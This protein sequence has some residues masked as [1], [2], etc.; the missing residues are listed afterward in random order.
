MATHSSILS[1]RIPGTGEPGASVYGVAQSRTRRKW[2]SSSGSSLWLGSL[3]MIT[4]R[5]IHVAAN[6]VYHS[7]LWLSG[8]PLCIHAT[9][10]FIHSPVD[11]RLFLSLGCC[12]HRAV[13]ISLSSGFVQTCAGWDSAPDASGCVICMDPL[14]PSGLSFLN[15]WNELF[16]RVLWGLTAMIHVKLLAQGMAQSKNPLNT[17]F[18]L[19]GS[20]SVGQCAPKGACP[21]TWIFWAQTQH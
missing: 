1:W 9:S 21:G 12:A 2:L 6:S 11:G 19:S 18:L 15:L 13:H 4:S 16:H 7:F 10:F 17:W 5:S 14:T 20:F 8:I 3:G